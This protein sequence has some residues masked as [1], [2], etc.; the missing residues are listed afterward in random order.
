MLLLGLPFGLSF[1]LSRAEVRVCSRAVVVAL[2]CLG[3]RK[4]LWLGLGLVIC[5]IIA[6]GGQGEAGL[7]RNL[8]QELSRALEALAEYL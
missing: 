2:D 8:T 1:G 3:L 7:L 4:C 5:A 6:E